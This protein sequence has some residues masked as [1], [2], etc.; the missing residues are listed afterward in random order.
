MNEETQNQQAPQMEMPTPEQIQIREAQRKAMIEFYRNDL[1]NLK[2]EA[3][4]NELQERIEKARYNTWQWRL[5]FDQMMA[6]P[7]N[8]EEGVNKGEENKEVISPLKPV[9]DSTDNK[10]TTNVVAMNTIAKEE[11]VEET[12]TPG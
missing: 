9:V 1:K 12:Q 6:P 3:E 7:P 8:Q 2:V 4:Y 11:K 5:R 10:D